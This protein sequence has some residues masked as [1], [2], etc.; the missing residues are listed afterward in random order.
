MSFEQRMNENETRIWVYREEEIR[1]GEEK[2]DW[3]LKKKSG[4]HFRKFIT[5]VIVVCTSFLLNWS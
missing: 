5:T 4:C 2:K 1:A 3:F